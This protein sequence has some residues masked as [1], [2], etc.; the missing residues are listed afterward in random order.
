ML[1]TEGLIRDPVNPF[2]EKPITSEPKYAGE[3]H[4]VE[5]DWHFASNAGNDFADKQVITFRGRDIT[6]IGNWIIG[7]E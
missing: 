2:T 4:L 1:A 3:L 6:D 5:T 7:D